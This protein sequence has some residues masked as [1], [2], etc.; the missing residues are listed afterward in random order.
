MKQR[1]RET[2]GVE[3]S[4]SWT[5]QWTAPPDRPQFHPLTLAFTFIL[6][7]SSAASPWSPLGRVGGGEGREGVLEGSLSA[8]RDPHPLSWEPS[9]GPV[10]T[11]FC[12]LCVFSVSLKSSHTQFSSHSMQRDLNMLL[13]PLSWQAL[14]VVYFCL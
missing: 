9:D 6:P 13:R 4:L 10:G 8:S 14:P 11:G 2:R 1:R 5:A 12:C 7:P 3:P